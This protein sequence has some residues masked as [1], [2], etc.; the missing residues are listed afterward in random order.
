VEFSFV[1]H[2]FGAVY[3]PTQVNPYLLIYICI[4][5]VLSNLLLNY[6]CKLAS[7]ELQGVSSIQEQILTLTNHSDTVVRVRKLSKADPS[8]RC[9]FLRDL[10]L[11]C[12]AAIQNKPLPG[13][14]VPTEF[15]MIGPR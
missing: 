5:H 13:E 9:D 15:V 10:S 3:V 4:F 6:I 2:D 14:S 8:F 1:S 12:G 7:L 11:A